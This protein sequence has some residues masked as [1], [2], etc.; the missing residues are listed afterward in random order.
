MS[1]T[2]TAVFADVQNIYYTTRDAYGR[3]FD[4]RKLWQLSAARGRLRTRSHTLLTEA[5]RSNRSFKVHC[6]ISALR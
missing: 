4:Y 3:A 6:V 2:R 1:H 5:T